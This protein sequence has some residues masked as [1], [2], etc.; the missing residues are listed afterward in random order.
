MIIPHDWPMS[1]MKTRGNPSNAFIA[2][3]GRSEHVCFLYHI[4]STHNG[5]ALYTHFVYMYKRV[6]ALLLV[7]FPPSL[8]YNVC[9]RLWRRERDAR[10]C[11]SS[12]TPRRRRHDLFFFS[13]LL[14]SK[15]LDEKDQSRVNNDKF[16]GILYDVHVQQ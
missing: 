1:T 12:L 7:L 6:A 15:L 9:T 14:L 4:F 10:L 13:L 16:E 2:L 11:T 3:F 5:T 8:F